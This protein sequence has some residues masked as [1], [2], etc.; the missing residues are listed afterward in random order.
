MKLVA[1]VVRLSGH[2]LRRVNIAEDL[3]VVGVTAGRALPSLL[4]LMLLQVD[5]RFHQYVRLRP[6]IT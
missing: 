4:V 6:K 3:A 2:D 1:G 5:F